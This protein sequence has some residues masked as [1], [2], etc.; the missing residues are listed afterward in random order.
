MGSPPTGAPNAGVGAISGY[1]DQSKTI[2]DR[3]IVATED[4]QKLVA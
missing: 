2:Q 3:D 1:T 4:Q